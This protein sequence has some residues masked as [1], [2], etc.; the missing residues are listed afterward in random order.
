M[1]NDTNTLNGALQELGETM[2]D[3]LTTM[4]VPSTYDEGLTTLAQK[5]LSI[6]PTPPTPTPAS[7]DLSLTAGKQILS[8]ADVSS[9]NEYATLTATVLDD[10]DDP[11]SGATVELYKDSVLWDTL[12]TGSAG[13][14]S[15]TY[16]SAGVGDVEFYAECGSLVTETY[17]IRD[18]VYYNPDTLTSSQTL[19]IPNIPTNFKATWKL[20][21][22][23]STTSSWFEIGTDSNNLFF[24]GQVGATIMGIYKKVNGSQSYINYTDAG[25]SLNTE[26]QVELTYENGTITLKCNNKTVT[27]SYTYASRDYVKLNIDNNQMSELMIMPL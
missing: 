11:V 16:A 5:I 14:V 15:K 6:G 17:T 19:N 23:G 26:Y 2:A 20:K 3:N 12:T 9:G 18:A 4:G 25:L 22:T 13:T 10:N 27:A 8:Y 21:K 7:L 1:T 24:G